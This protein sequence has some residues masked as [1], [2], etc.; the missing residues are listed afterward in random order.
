MPWQSLHDADRWQYGE[1]LALAGRYRDAVDVLT[2]SE[3]ARGWQDSAE[4]SIDAAQ[5]LAWAKRQLAP[6]NAPDRALETIERWYAD[7]E[8]AGLLHLSLD[9]QLFARNALLAG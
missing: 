1:L 5:T 4:L 9:R 2:Q 6:K 8:R 3:P 7:H